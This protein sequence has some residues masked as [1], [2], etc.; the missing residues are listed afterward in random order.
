ML[1]FVVTAMYALRLPCLYHI[2]DIAIESCS[3]SC[4]GLNDFSY[5]LFGGRYLI[6]RRRQRVGGRIGRL[7]PGEVTFVVGEMRTL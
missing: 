7:G 1:L 3:K 4:G 2:L 6:Q 5:E